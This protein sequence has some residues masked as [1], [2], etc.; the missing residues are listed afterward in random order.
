MRILMYTDPHFS[1]YSS[2]VRGRGEKYSIRLENLIDSINWAEGLATLEQCNAVFVLGDFFDKSEL[3]AEEI[4][5]LKE[6]KWSGLSHIF[7]VG[8]HELARHTLEFS[9]SHL[10]DMCPN[11][12]VVDSPLS[13]RIDG[14]EDTEI[15]FLPYRFNVDKPI[16]EYFNSDK[17]NCNRRIVFSHNDL[18]G[19]NYGAFVSKEGFEVSD[20]E[21]YCDLFINGHLH[22]GENIS[23]KVINLGNL[24]GQNFSEDA[25]KYKHCAAILDTKTLRLDYYENPIALNF[26]K[27]DEETFD[28]CKTE[29]DNLKN[30]SV[31]TVKCSDKDAQAVK[32]EIAKHSNIIESR[33]MIETTKETGTLLE[34]KIEELTKMDHIQEFRS[35]ITS[36][37]GNND[38]VN[39]ELEEI[40]K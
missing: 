8:N 7:L 24:T 30:N 15:C 18:K 21:N 5:A 9:S 35:Y 36:T 6:I 40:S 39:E 13:Y 1:Q 37:L 11:T 32:D 19:I 26:Y 25:A 27:I 34:N 14:E 12:L 3:C 22:N 28:D 38:I 16:A 4:T 31:I 10:F 29:L 2:I 23:K 17:S 20:I 33:V